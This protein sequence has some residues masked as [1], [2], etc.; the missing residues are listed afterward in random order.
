MLTKKRILEAENNLRIYFQD[1]L[2]KKEKFKSI[3]FNV[4]L[5][6]ANDSLRTAQFLSKNEKSDLWIIVSS[7]Y[8]MYYLSNA[9]IYKLGHKIGDNISHKITADALIVFV[10]N[11]L[12]NK[13]LEDYEELQEQALATIKADNLIE[14][15]DYERKK[16]GFI[17]YKTEE[18]EKH[19]KAQTSLKRAKEFFLEI[20]KII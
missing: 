19:S 4:L 8:A 13:L 2:I 10:R 9:L 18:I 12:K 1:D 14:N 7:Y 3:V 20:E 6:N 15:F 16:R 5:N 17:Q 11:K